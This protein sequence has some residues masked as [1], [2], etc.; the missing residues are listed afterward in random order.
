MLLIKTNVKD[1]NLWQVAKVRDFDHDESVIGLKWND[2]WFKTEGV[3]D[4][5]KPFLINE[6]KKNKWQ[7]VLE[8]CPEQFDTQSW[9]NV[10]SSKYPTMTERTG[11]Q[12]LKECSE[13]PMANKLS[14]GLYKKN[15]RLITESEL[16]E[17]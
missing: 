13:S 10:F 4:D 8:D 14:H 7:S 9:L 2:F 17:L 1:F 16:D 12:W 11:K 6:E 3:I 15:L 5:Y